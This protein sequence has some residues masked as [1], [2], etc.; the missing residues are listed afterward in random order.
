MGRLRDGQRLD[1]GHVGVEPGG[2]GLLQ[3]EQPLCHELGRH[4]DHGQV[5]PLGP[6]RPLLARPELTREQDGPGVLVG[7]LDRHPVLPQGEGDGGADQAGA[8]DQDAPDTGRVVAHWAMST[9]R[10]TAP[11]R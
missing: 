8:D 7:E 6:G 11:R 3:V 9:L 10:A 4:G 5:D 2:L 1:A